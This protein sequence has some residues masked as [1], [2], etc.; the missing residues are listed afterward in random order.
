VPAVARLSAL[1]HRD[2]RLVFLGLFVSITGTQMQRVAVAWQ[3]YQLTGSAVAM[4]FLGFARVAPVLLL[5]VGGGVVADA[6][7]R[8]KLMMA[9]QSALALVSLGL[10]VATYTQHI[11]PPII[12]GL[13]AIAGAAVAF[14]LPARQSLLPHLVPLSDLSNALSLNGV[15]FEMGAVLGPALG[16]W[17]IAHHSVLPIYLF[18]AASFGAVILAL[19]LIKARPLVAPGARVRWS[20]V[21]EGFRFLQRSPLIWSTMIL[22]FLATFFAGSL[23]LL[24]IF[25]DQVLKVGP[26][27]LGLLYAAQPAG[28]ALVGATLSLRPAIDRQGRALLIA[29]AVYGAAV[30][31]LGLSRH[32]AVAMFCLFI[33]G[34]ADMV[35]TVIRQTMRQLLTPDPL[36]GRMTAATGMF[37]IGGPQL[38]ELEAGLVAGLISVPFSITSGGLACLL[39][40]IVV[41]LRVPSLA[42]YRHAEPTSTDPPR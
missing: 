12:Y 7:D 10:A 17:I 3:L 23:L 14:D 40:V 19:A 22:D 16:G 42:R 5:T 4:G 39:M 29:V 21:V 27:A 32:L 36:R 9:S 2:F 41:G 33:A 26:D 1:Q 28:A 34:A 13:A 25:A 24:P 35:S 31:A 20:A 11:S 30:A 38:G 8:R 37:F 15:A 18:D 6:F